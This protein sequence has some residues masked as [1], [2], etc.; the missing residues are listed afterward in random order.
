VTASCDPVGAGNLRSLPRSVPVRRPACLRLEG[1]RPN[2]KVRS[3]DP[4]VDRNEDYALTRRTESPL[5][6]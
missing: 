2:E 5:L 1:H 4:A 6:V 3:V